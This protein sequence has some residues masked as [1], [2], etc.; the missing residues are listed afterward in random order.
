M[1]W[2]KTAMAWSLAALLFATATGGLIWAQ[3]PG[4]PDLP[5]S[6][7]APKAGREQANPAVGVGQPQVGAAVPNSTQVPVPAAKPPSGVN[8]YQG[9]TAYSPAIPSPFG[10]AEADDPETAKLRQAESALAHKSE[11]LVAQYAATEDDEQRGGVK[12]QLAESLSQQFSVQQQLRERELARV[13]ARVKKL[14]E[15]TEKRREAQRTIVEQRLDQLLREADGLGWTPPGAAQGAPG[16]NSFPSP[17]PA[18]QQFFYKTPPGVQQNRPSTAAP[19]APV[20]VL[21]RR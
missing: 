1:K 3:Q 13:E 21:P 10:A 14:R 6:S 15:L 17:Q 16:A 8:L 9:Q 4:A 20:N 7:A 18:F 12:T 5:A 11:Q 2:T 19:A